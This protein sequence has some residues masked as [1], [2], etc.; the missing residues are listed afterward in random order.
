MVYGPKFYRHRLALTKK[1]A[2]SLFTKVL[3][4]AKVRLLVVLESIIHP[5]EQLPQRL[6]VASQ[7][8]NGPLRLCNIITYVYI[9]IYTYVCMYIHIL[10]HTYMHAI[11]LQG[12]LGD[13][14]R[15]LLFEKPCGSHSITCSR[16]QGGGTRLPEGDV[17]PSFNLRGPIVWPNQ[18]HITQ[19]VQTPQD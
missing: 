17:G 1:R 19:R 13:L 12:A 11:K 4:G 10:Y 2:P 16:F 9:Y 5:G 18:R 14:D 8:I 6:H 15:T 3:L 7:Y